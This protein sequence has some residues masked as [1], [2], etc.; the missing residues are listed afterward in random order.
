MEVVLGE[1]IKTKQIVIMVFSILFSVSIFL[2][3]LNSG[4]VYYL[5]IFIVALAFFTGVNW[6]Y[7]NIYKIRVTDTAIFCC[8]LYHAKIFDIAQFD[9]IVASKKWIPPFILFPFP[10][11]PYFVIKIINDKGYMFM[12]SSYKS[13][14]SMFNNEKNL[15]DLNAKVN[16]VLTSRT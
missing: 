13:F 5:M 1:N 4:N 2:V 15:K 12:D 7:S 10:S 8:N 14:F 11:P 16:L 9:S 6:L 3:T